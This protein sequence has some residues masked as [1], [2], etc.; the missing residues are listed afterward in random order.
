MPKA[1]L[2]SGRLWLAVVTVAIAAVALF[3]V[4]P[5]YRI[6]LLG[7]GYMAQ[8][9]CAG[10]FVSGRAFDDV[11]AQDLT[12]PGLG[13]L[14]LFT[15]SVNAKER[16]VSAS[17]FGLAHRTAI[18]RDG[19]GCTLIDDRTPSQLRAETAG[20][21]PASEPP[22]PN[23]EWPEGAEV[24]AG[25]WRDNF[26]WPEG[27]D[28][29]MASRAVD[30]IFA[31]RHPSHARG[32]RALVVVQ[33][34]RIVAERYAPGFDATMPLVGWSMSKTAT[35]ALVGLRVEDGTLAL[36]DTRLMPQWQEPEAPRGAITLNELMRMT[37]GLA[38]DEDADDNLSDLSQMIFVRGNTAKFAA[39]QP[40]DHEPGTHWSY[41]SGSTAILSGVLRETFD[42]E[43]DYLRFP[44]VRLFAPLGM[45]TALL[46]PDASGTLMGGA[47]LYAS[48]R[49][50]AR[51]GLLFLHDGKWR[52]EQLLPEG[53]V[54]YT[55]ESTPQS[56][57]DEYGAQVWLKLTSSP[58][59]GEPPMPADTYYMLGHQRQVVAMIPSKA[60]V[61][62]RLGL[63]PSGGDWDTARELS[64]L[65]NA[66]PDKT[67]GPGF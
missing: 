10:I 35:N 56:P 32:T 37:S 8:Q 1:L 48:A 59:L 61:V 29:P 25:P 64:P 47:F 6:A 22:A 41:S 26:Q 18:Y 27:V 43:R 40:L 33:G 51:L 34:G 24:S 54:A 36:D 13:P 9:L 2:R 65:V 55:T 15:P 5:L 57:D 38:F 53:W 4:A 14:S 62:V 44:R 19:L 17:A 11:M 3:V 12:G 31:E 28:G 21:F 30:A 67:P 60:L 66:F 52:G 58:G 20:L 39:S 50:W 49:D 63:T 16:D 45:R 42:D 7:S 23:A 46:P